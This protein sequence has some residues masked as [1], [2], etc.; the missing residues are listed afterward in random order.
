MRKNFDSILLV[1]IALVGIAMVVVTYLSAFHE[2][3]ASEIFNSPMPVDRLVYRAGDNIIGK[4]NY[5]RYTNVAFDTSISFVN[6]I[7]L[8]TPTRHAT[9]APV[10][11]GTV[12][13]V[14]ATVPDAL[15]PGR[16]HLVGKNEY[17]VNFL[18]TRTT[19]WSTV[20]FEVDDK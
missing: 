1:G 10:G 8:D 14:L 20:E 16:Y 13:G 5:C 12:F 9:G 19:E 11:C 7:I 3:P 15:P 4:I 6:N 2:N 17:R 18:A